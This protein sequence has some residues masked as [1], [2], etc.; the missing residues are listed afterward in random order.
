MTV[1]FVTMVGG[2]IET[3]MTIDKDLAGA[4]AANRFG[5]GA[6]PG[7]IDAARSDPQGWL[8]AQI[9]SQGA[10]P[11]RPDMPASSVRLVEYRDLQKTRREAR[12]ADAMASGATAPDPVKQVQQM[13]RRDAGAD[14]VLRLKLGGE[15][16]A[17]FRERW[18]LFWA[19]HFTV[20]AAKVV[21]ATLIGPFEQEAIRPHVF[22]RFEDMLA[23]TSSH[24]AMLLYLDQAQSIGPDSKAAVYLQRLGKDGGLN[25]NLGREILE[26]HTVGVD[27]GYT[28]ADVT[29]FARALTGW[30]VGGL[31]DPDAGRFRFRD[32]A[33]E[34]GAR[35]V[36][37]RRYPEAGYDQA[38]WVLRDLAANPHTARRLARKIAVHFVSDE[39]PTS[40]V[41]RLE[42]A[43]RASGGDLATVARALVQAPESWSA[44]PAKFKTPYEFMVSAW[45]AT[46]RGPQDLAALG[47]SLSAMGQRPFS[48]PSPKGW[49]EEASAWCAPDG[50]VKRMAW[51]ESYSAAAVGERDPVQLAQAA[52]GAG[53]APLTARTI[54]RA[55]S[56]GEGLSILLMSPE[57]QR[58]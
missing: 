34:P 42:T 7:E 24:P 15:T 21:T 11:I 12:A 27:A 9:R 54:G 2:N 51:A 1:V 5:L 37:G 57:F 25:E 44:A 50:I 29:E 53:L 6:R 41:D 10:D 4:I 48:A 43:W 30:S 17:S 36:M 18:A 33:H 8:A 3:S 35:R 31:A 19:N 22:G 14:F 32:A 52:L 56:R 40:L 58:R 13:I 23:A 26:L 20:S 47:P 49:P 39:P 55:E 16:D 46:G 28:Q 45:R 38:R